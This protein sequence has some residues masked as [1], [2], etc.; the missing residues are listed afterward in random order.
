MSDL[1]RFENNPKT[2][3][4]IDFTIIDVGHMLKI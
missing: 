4:N 1:M 2:L 3:K